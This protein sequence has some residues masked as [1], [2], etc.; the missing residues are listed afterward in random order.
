MTNIR[1]I[2]LMKQQDGTIEVLFWVEDQDEREV[3]V[4]LN[5]IEL[6]ELMGQV[7]LAR[8]ICK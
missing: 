7:S 5:D 6:E 8:E 4:Q 1:N 3:C 2:K